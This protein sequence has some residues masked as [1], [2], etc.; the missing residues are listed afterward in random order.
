MLSCLH[1]LAMILRLK[2]DFN[3]DWSLFDLF[4]SFWIS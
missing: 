3:L 2:G 1:F 4:A